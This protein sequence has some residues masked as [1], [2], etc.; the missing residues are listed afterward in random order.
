MGKKKN[1][2]TFYYFLRPKACTTLL[3]EYQQVMSYIK[4][5][6]DVFCVVL[7]RRRIIRDGGVYV[8]TSP[9]GLG[10]YSKGFW[11]DISL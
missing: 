10:L 1:I 11:F 8:K 4:L 3:M 6:N 9:Y 2:S 7:T 5:F